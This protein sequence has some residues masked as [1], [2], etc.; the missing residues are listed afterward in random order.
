MSCLIINISFSALP[1]NVRYSKCTGDYCGM[2]QDRIYVRFWNYDNQFNRSLIVFKKNKDVFANSSPI[3]QLYC[4]KMYICFFTSF[5]PP[6]QNF[7]QFM[8]I[9]FARSPSARVSVSTDTIPLTFSKTDS[10]Q[11]NTNLFLS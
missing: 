5:I 11:K 6:N 7:I 1:L 3:W 9:K 2:N 10:Q 8:S 4:Y